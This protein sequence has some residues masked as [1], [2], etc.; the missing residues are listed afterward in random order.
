MLEN[1][2]WSAAAYRAKNLLEALPSGRLC[3]SF[4]RSEDIRHVK[5]MA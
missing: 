5:Q 1:R 4:D 3:I 2:H